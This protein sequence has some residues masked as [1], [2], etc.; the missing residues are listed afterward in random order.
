MP[1]QSS[2]NWVLKCGIK[3]VLRVMKN[4]IKFL[5]FCID[6]GG[7]VGGLNGMGV[8]LCQDGFARAMLTKKKN[9]MLQI[10]GNLSI[11]LSLY[12]IDHPLRCEFMGK[13]LS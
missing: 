7:S 11:D 9:M 12:Q 2:S 8:H 4:F 10:E 6:Q 5:L 1:Y 3:N 13:H